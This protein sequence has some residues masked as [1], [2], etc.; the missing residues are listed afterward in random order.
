MSRRSA[1]LTVKLSPLQCERD[2]NR[3]RILICSYVDQRHG[4]LGEDNGD[5]GRASGIGHRELGIGKRGSKTKTKK[6]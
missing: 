6:S 3:S 5:G 4:E 1:L 2:E